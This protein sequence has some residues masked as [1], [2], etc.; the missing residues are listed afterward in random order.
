MRSAY[1][2]SMAPATITENPH[3][4]RHKPG[5]GSAMVPSRLIRIWSAEVVVG[6]LTSGSHAGCGAAGGAA[7]CL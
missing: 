1:T 6:R 4:D 2:A 3:R 5:N 7:G